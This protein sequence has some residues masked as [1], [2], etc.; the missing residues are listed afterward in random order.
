[1][2]GAAASRNGSNQAGDLRRMTALLQPWRAHVSR[3]HPSQDRLLEVV[4][5]KTDT[6]TAISTARHLRRCARCTHRA[7]Q[8]RTFLDTLANDAGASFDEIFPP[9]RLRTQRTRIDHRLAQAIGKVQPARVL[10]FPFR[11]TPGRRTDL[12]PARWA[13]AAT[14]A[15]LVLGM[16]TGQLLHFHPYP[17]PMPD[18]GAAFE[19]GPEPRAGARVDATLDM[20]G[21][22]ELPPPS[23][24][25]TTPAPLT[26]SEFEQVMTEATFLDTLDVALISLPVAE[27]E[28]IDALTPH[29]RDLAATIR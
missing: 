3:R 6:A 1:M 24:G 4:S 19:A 12:R 23:T 13:L 25:E 16:V 10:A 5:G 26:L 21:T 20:T 14:A 18:V 2:K 15:G 22:V 9:G 28:S 8:I 7:G 17:P 11:R 27:L 29:V